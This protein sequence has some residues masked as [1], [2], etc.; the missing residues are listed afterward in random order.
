MAG[1]Q[2]FARR[3]RRPVRVVALAG[4]VALAG[5]GLTGCLRAAATGVGAGGRLGVV[6]TTPVVADFV[7]Q[8]GGSRVSVTEIL[9]PNVDP[10]DYE[11][12]PADLLALAR[13]SVVV[14]NGAGLESWLGPTITNSGFAGLLVDASHGVPLR[15]LDGQTDPHIWHDPDNAEIMCRNIAAGLST[16]DPAGRTSYRANLDRY[17]S[18]LDALDSDLR[19]RIDQIPPAA[20]TLVTNHDAFG[21]YGRH[22]G[23]TV[24]S[25]LPSFDTS[26]ELSGRDIERVVARI[27]RTG[28]RAVFSESALPARVARTIGREAGVRVVAG[29]GSLYA[30]TLGPPG[31]PAA[32]Y[33]DMEE[34]NTEV[35]VGALS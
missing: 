11:P 10:H 2:M 16:R 35:I 4:L 24:D 30:D 33:L 5:S 1:R 27:R 12:A 29:A 23:L 14:R 17:L 18:R 13:A 15:R 28:A 20:R 21:Y 19:A 8:V 6:A 25:V 7:R 3:W 34:H 31:S 26:A 22:F 9:R 32:T